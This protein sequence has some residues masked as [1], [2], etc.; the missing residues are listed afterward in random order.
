MADLEK[1]VFDSEWNLPQDSHMGMMAYAMVQ[2]QATFLTYRNLRHRV[3]AIGG[4]PA[5]EKLLSLVSIDE[6]AH[7]D[8]F[9]QCVEMFL[10]LDREA[11]LVALRR[12]IEEFRMP[13]LHD[14]L[15]N[16]AR[17]IAQ[18]RDLE[19]FNEEIFYRDVMF[20][21]LRDLN[22]SKREFRPSESPRK[23]VASR[24]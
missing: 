19:I 5:L 12:V 13:A 9:M 3:K 4:D 23:S 24:Q 2:E 16:S 22:I 8:F 1:R 10:K 21:V 7:H 17:R 14:L 18:V 6:A 11:C 20:T 15:D